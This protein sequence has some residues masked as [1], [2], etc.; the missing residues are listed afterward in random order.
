V[1]HSAGVSSSGRLDSALE[2]GIHLLLHPYR[3]I[4]LYQERTL[5]EA[6]RASLA[7]SSDAATREA[8][9]YFQ[10]TAAP[11][12][13][14]DQ[15]R[16]QADDAL[17]CCIYDS[18]RTL[19]AFEVALEARGKVGLA[20]C[21]RDSGPSS[22]AGLIRRLMDSDRGYERILQTRPECGINLAALATQI[23]GFHDPSLRQRQQTVFNSHRKP[24]MAV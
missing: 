18:L 9:E 4:Q 1:Q 10:Q 6:L 12:Q 20:V 16:E 19:D 21:R 3:S 15:F 13:V 23:L 24:P 14:S 11:A 17:V 22:P 7:A 8:M 2:I 5:S